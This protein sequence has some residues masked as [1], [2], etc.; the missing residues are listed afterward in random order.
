MQETR[1]SFPD[2]KVGLRETPMNSPFLALTPQYN[3]NGNSFLFL[4]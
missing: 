4:D 2:A 1:N 3:A